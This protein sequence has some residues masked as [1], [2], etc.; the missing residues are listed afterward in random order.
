MPRPSQPLQTRYGK[1]R[2]LSERTELGRR[3]VTVRCDC[4]TKKDVFADQ[5]LG[6]RA[7]S[8]GA[9]KCRSTHAPVRAIKGYTP[10][11][12]RTMSTERLKKYWDLHTKD[13]I[14]GTAI[15]EEYA[16]NRNTLYA[17]FRAVRRAGGWEKYAKKCA[18]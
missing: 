11:G 3:I 13:G 2:V 9:F 7:R 8:C 14:P 1:L 5:L 18:Q 15:A 4:G 12:P 10:S 17:A 6:G 16:E